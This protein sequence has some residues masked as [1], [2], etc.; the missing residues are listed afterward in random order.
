[1]RHARCSAP[2]QRD[3]C[4]LVQ[5]ATSLSTGGTRSTSSSKRKC[6]IVRSLDSSTSAMPVERRLARLSS[7]VRP[8]HWH[9]VPNGESTGA[10]VSGLTKAAHYLGA[11]SNGDAVPGERQ[12]LTVDQIAFI[13][14]FGYLVLPG[15]VS[16]KIADIVAAF[17]AVWDVDTATGLPRRAAVNT[18][19]VHDDSTR[20]YIVP[21]IDQH[22]T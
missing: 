4:R 5:S 9:V 7:H 20:S 15:L 8:V 19:T 17:S 14:T 1:M 12:L 10:T 11:A 13:D 22:P 21:F 2:P 18:G 3:V 6:S 16:D